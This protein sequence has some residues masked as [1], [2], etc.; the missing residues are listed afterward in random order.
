MQKQCK[1]NEDKPTTT[2]GA[3]ARACGDS[4]C[5]V[6]L[7]D[8]A[9]RSGGSCSSSAALRARALVRLSL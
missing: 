5:G 8:T 4:Q 2:T 7:V 1:S 9:L 6:L 3:R